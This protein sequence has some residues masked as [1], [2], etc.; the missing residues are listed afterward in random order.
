MAKKHTF[1]ELHQSIQD[2][3]AAQAEQ[4][5]KENV[6]RQSESRMKQAQRVAQIGSW[7]MNVETERGFWSDELF[8]LLGYQPGEK[9][10]SYSLF[11]KH[12]HLDDVEKFDESLKK[13][14]NNLKHVDETFRFITKNGD[15]RFAHSVGRIEFNEAGKALRAF[16]T[17]QDIT[18]R[19]Q[20]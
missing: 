4:K 1:E 20:L 15:I 14:T 2:L 3:E 18:E 16:G 7:D 10:S 12:V 8:R 5:K 17:F 13:Y 9:T 19:M 6:L 11:R